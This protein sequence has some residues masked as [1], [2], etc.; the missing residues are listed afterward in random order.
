MNTG[1]FSS[2]APIVMITLLSIAATAQIVDFRNTQ[3]DYPTPA[4]RDVYFPDMTPLIGTNF[5]ARLLY[6]SDPSNLQPATYSS[7]ARFRNV[8]PGVAVAGTWVGSNRTLAGFTYGDTVTLVVQ[9]WDAGPDS[10]PGTPGRTFDQARNGGQLWMQSSP[11]AYQIP[12]PGSDI[13]KYYMDGFRG[14]RPLSCPPPGRISIVEANGQIQLSFNGVQPVE[15]SE[16]LVAWSAIGFQNSSY[17]DT[18]AA[19]LNRRFYRLRCNGF[20]SPNYVGFYRVNLRAGYNF[21]GNHLLLPDDRIVE[22][23]PAPPDGTAVYP[24]DPMSGGYL[25]TQYISPAAGGTGWEGATTMHLRPGGGVVVYAPS[26]FSKTFVGEVILNSTNRLPVG[27]SLIS[28]M[29]PQSLP[30]TGIPELSFPVAEGDTIYQ[31]DF[32][33]GG[34]RINQFLLGAWE[35]DNGGAPPASALGE[36]F[37]LFREQPGLWIRDIRPSP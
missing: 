16:D 32:A 19:S 8:T 33:T 11:F 7:P 15:V 27:Y 34:Y 25:I 18:N 26:A 30:L 4:D 3:V 6:G 9:V 35:G 13:Q 23:F 29:I 37:F 24:F 36:C 14:I 21:L 1:R 31:F 2:L 17:T 5:Q 10:A 20:F 12:P 28:S 22:I